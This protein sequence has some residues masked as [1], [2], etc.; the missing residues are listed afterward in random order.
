MTFAYSPVNN[1][2]MAVDSLD[3]FKEHHILTLN[4]DSARA[5]VEKLKVTEYDLY[6]EVTED[7]R[8]AFQAKICEEEVSDII[9]LGHNKAEAILEH[10]EKSFVEAVALFIYNK[11][12]HYGVSV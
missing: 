11:L 12:Y 10:F 4:P 8:E 1:D 5:F 9:M 2:K 7:I 3:A 6:C